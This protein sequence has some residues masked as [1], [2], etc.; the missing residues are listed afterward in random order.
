M[1][2]LRDD[3]TGV[4][5]VSGGVYRA[6]DALPDGVS[7]AESLLAPEPAKAAPKRRAR[8][9]AADVGDL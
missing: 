2:N 8:K 6:G 5:H 9:G 4:V 3:L 1:A 7:V